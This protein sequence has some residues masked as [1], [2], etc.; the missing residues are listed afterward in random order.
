ML[1]FLRTDKRRMYVDSNQY[2]TIHYKRGLKWIARLKKYITNVTPSMSC[3]NSGNDKA[4]TSP[5]T[6]K[7]YTRARSLVSTILNV[8]LLRLRRH[9]DS[10]NPT[11]IYSFV[12][13][14]RLAVI[15]IL[16]FTRRIAIDLPPEKI[17][18]RTG[19]LSS[20][21]LLP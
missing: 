17:E 2:I 13:F 10:I 3:V 1:R 12:R 7:Y 15:T 14:G 9:Q 18:Y 6:Y 8:L 21:L 5:F 20:S 16:E 19:S 11:V 4:V